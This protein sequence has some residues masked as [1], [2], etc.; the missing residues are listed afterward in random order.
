MQYYKLILTGFFIL[1][2]AVCISQHPSFIKD[3]LDNYI[4][5][6]LKDWDLPGLAIVIVKD[7]K[8][9]VMKGYGVRDNT[10]KMPVNENTLF[11]IASNSKLFTGLVLAQLE[12][13]EKLSLN[14]RI[15]RYFPDYKLFDP[16]TTQ[17]VTI[18]DLLSHR[19]G[20]KT[21]QG[22]FTF[23]NSQLSRS[24]IMNRMRLLRPSGL[25]R[26]D[27]GY[28][29]SCYLTAGEVVSKV[30]G[31]TW[32]QY[33]QD[34]LLT[35]LQMSRSTAV[36]NGMETMENVSRPYTTNFT[37][38]LR[39]V[40]YDQWDNLGP[41]AS[42]I[43]N[44]ND[45]SHWLLFQLDSGKYNGRRLMSFSVLEKT[46]DINTIINSRKS[47]R[48][49]VHIRGYGLGLFVTDYNG[50]Q[51][52]WHTGGAGGMLSNVCF[53]PEERLGIAILTNNDNQ[54]FF[55]ALRYQVLDAY[56]RV[57]Y[58][59]RSNQLLEPFQQEMQDQLKKI[60][61]WKLRIN[62]NTPALP[63]SAYTGEYNNEL[64]GSLTITQKNRQLAI[65]FNSHKNLTAV[66]DYMDKDEWL[67]Q[68]DNILYG[69]FAIKFR[70]QNEKVVSI[71][72]KANEFVEY[73]PYTFMKL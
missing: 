72:I 17:Q 16:V 59:N 13:Q 29:N 23:W 52:F 65:R 63:L 60:A 44:V 41:A 21:F 61:G 51:V 33:V 38:K 35:P 14:D 36:S 15:T 34:S 54:N 31:R 53:V 47:S 58:I 4:R 56:L 3:S 73:D 24:E 45:L 9:E 11:M 5:Q 55:E 50:R 19:I 7:G 1:C 37:G 2:N 48:F 30:T 66:L 12:T 39:Q 28:C 20:T 69:I 10:S 71:E 67:M 8:V 62:N 40:P 6:G 68:Y 46:R 25:F 57:P 18:R 26:Q 49:P 42:I 70:I 43:S 27:Y 22:D 64:Y 32:E